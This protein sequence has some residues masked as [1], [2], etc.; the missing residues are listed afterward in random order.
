VFE[1]V[2][3]GT[4]LVIA[5]LG[6]PVLDGLERKL[7]AKVHSRLGPPILQT[8]YDILKLLRKEIIL[9]ANVRIVLYLVPLYYGLVCLLVLF[10]ML[11]IIGLPNI[12][13]IAFIIIT[14][15]FA[16]G[17]FVII[18]VLCSNPFSIVGSMREVAL[19]LINEVA[20][21]VALTLLAYFANSLNLSDIIHLSYTPSYIVLALLIIVATYVLA[22][23]VPFDIA[24][25]EPELASG[26]LIELSGP[27]L[28]IF[29]YGNLIKRLAVSMLASYIIL[30]PLLGGVS[31]LVTLC[32]TLILAGVIW[33][34]YAL[35]A[36]ILARSRVDLAPTTLFKIFLTLSVISV[37]LRHLGL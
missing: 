29:I 1:V 36:V 30:A 17:I 20:L 21:A 12:Y 3:L 2:I 34:L 35:T 28:G 4:L 25:A 27:L 7:K 23:R 26:I 9:P 31:H 18:P 15:A 22:G 24:E 37:I 19:M 32:L 5:I 10:T 16:Q 33:L 11:G 14:I 6:A 8:W 13:S